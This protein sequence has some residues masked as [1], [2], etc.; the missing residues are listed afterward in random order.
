MGRNARCRSRKY[1]AS[2][3][4]SLSVAAAD[5]L[6]AYDWLGNVRELERV[7]ERAVALA[8]GPFLE[9]DD[10]PSPLLGGYADVLLPA[11]RARSTM[12]MWGSRTRGSCSRDAAITSGSHGVFGLRRDSGGQSQHESGRGYARDQ[13]KARHAKGRVDEAEWI[14]VTKQS[15]PCSPNGFSEGLRPI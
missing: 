12:R 7:I 3:S 15:Q 13:V 1:R 2:S 9:L 11:L 10:L 14:H 5:A 8:G 6:L 4:T